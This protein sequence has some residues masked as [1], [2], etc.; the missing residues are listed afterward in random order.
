MTHAPLMRYYNEG[1]EDSRIRGFKGKKKSYSALVDSSN[2][3]AKRL[4]V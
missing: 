2:A 1:S 4:L 3:A